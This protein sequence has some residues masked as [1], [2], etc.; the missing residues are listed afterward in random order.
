MR[1]YLILVESQEEADSIEVLLRVYDPSA[2]RQKPGVIVFPRS[3]LGSM[4]TASQVFETLERSLADALVWVPE[5]DYRLT[6]IVG[7][8]DLH[9]LN[10]LEIGSPFEPA[11]AMLVLAFP[12]VHWVFGNIRSSAPVSEIETA[13]GEPPSKASPREKELRKDKSDHPLP[14]FCDSIPRWHSLTS[15]LRSPFEPLF[16]LSG[17]REYI[18]KKARETKDSGDNGKQLA[19]FIPERKE[20]AS[21]LDDELN[22]AYFNAYV[23]YRYGFRAIPIARLRLAR[24][25]FS[26]KERVPYD[27]R[28]SLEDLYPSMP[29][30]EDHEH[31]SDLDGIKKS[32]SR[33]EVLYGLY[34][35]EPGVRAP[36]QSYL[37]HE[38]ARRIIVTSLHK[39]PDEDVGRSNREF[40]R[41]TGIR[42]VK[43]PY[44]GMFTFRRAIATPSE[45]VPPQGARVHR[46]IVCWLGE[47]D[48]VGFWG[49][50]KCRLGELWMKPREYFQNG[51]SWP[52]RA[53]ALD[54]RSGHSAPG[55]MNLLATALV[56]RASLLLQA[57][58]SS[59]PEACRGAVLAGLAS[60][61]YGGQVP[62]A[63]VDALILKHEFEVAA[64]CQF[65]GIGY[66][67]EIQPRLAEVR[68]EL[69]GIFSR[70]GRLLRSRHADNAEM[71]LVNGL[72]RV[73][74][75]H[76]QFNE[77][78]ALRRRLFTLDNRLRRSDYIW[79]PWRVPF[80]PVRF[81]AD[82]YLEWVS[83]S[84][85][86][87]FLGAVFWGVVLSLVYGK[88]AILEHLITALGFPVPTSVVHAIDVS[89]GVEVGETA[90]AEAVS[91]AAPIWL[92]FTG[93]FGAVLGLTHFGLLVSIL[94]TRL[95]RK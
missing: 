10:P 4:S 54:Q 56:R 16:D 3:G 81:L 68:E 22:Y 30:A 51:F 52:P 60:E 9:R 15:L 38:K 18:K 20:L 11:V 8:V 91:A 25:L 14:D 28:L 84:L 5:V 69:R 78:Q 75:D 92:V 48:Q 65:S 62:T 79:S 83:S 77:E 80:L 42:V 85:K 94:Y 87:L 29:D 61:L 37:P 67:I 72:T 24:E 70:H 44:S 82:K 63:S 43:K 58:V 1:K 50:W 46:K 41:R 33:R 40:L 6:V 49:H 13:K 19:W 55:R 26:Q 36:Q 17:L 89:T 27:I 53:P 74:M 66:S 47:G 73:F 39:T 23:A 7:R 57:G 31:L 76:A 93:T 45:C 34:C 12:E 88:G 32:R 95:T 71:L 86:A 90:T 59:A 2:R 21:S 64:E 35:A